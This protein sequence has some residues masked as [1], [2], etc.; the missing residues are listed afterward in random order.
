MEARAIRPALL[1]H[2]NEICAL[3]GVRG[4]KKNALPLLKI[5]YHTSYFT[6]ASIF[7]DAKLDILS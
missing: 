5:I 2:Q 7:D 1:C 6:T 3:V 4:V